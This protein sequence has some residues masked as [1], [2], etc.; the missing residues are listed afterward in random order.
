M[1][2]QQT[3]I[4]VGNGKKI[5]TKNGGV[6]RKVSLNLSRIA[7]RDVEEFI[8]TVASGKQYLNIV[9][10][11]RSEPDKYDNDVEVT[12]DTWRPTG[13]TNKSTGGGFSRNRPLQSRNDG[14]F[15][16]AP[17]EDEGED[18]PF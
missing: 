13:E 4:Y 18:L 17:K 5:T 8:K 12:V 14:R 9:I 1:S 11:D 2:E 16:E 7:E 10:F 6:F 3:K 15:Q